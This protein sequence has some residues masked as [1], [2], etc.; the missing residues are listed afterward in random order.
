M[1]VPDYGGALGAF[2]SNENLKFATLGCRT[3]Q[4]VRFS[5]LSLRAKADDGTAVKTRDAC[6]QFTFQTM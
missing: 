4:I 2:A 5:S 6:S 3:T 1:A